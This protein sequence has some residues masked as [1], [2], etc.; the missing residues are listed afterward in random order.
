MF[1]PL[2]AA[3][4]Y[5]VRNVECC[6]D[7]V[8]SSYTPTLTAL[9]RA[10]MS[11]PCVS[12]LDVK[13]S[14]TAVTNAH[15]AILP[16]LSNVEEE[17]TQA[18]ATA[19]EANIRVINNCMDEEATITSV[20]G[21]FKGAN[22]VHI[23]CHGVQDPENALSSAFCLSDGDLTVSRLMELDLKDVFFVF[24]SACETAKGDEKQPDQIVHLAATM[25]FVGFP[26]VIATMW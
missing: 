14:L 2:H 7:Y 21:A 25:L 8:V 1:L 17:I 6:A 10:Q 16:P 20:T 26:S 19:Q 23:A 12:K 9:S 3:G 18:Q 11:N 5:G 24:L 4:I 15:D 13:L 22:M